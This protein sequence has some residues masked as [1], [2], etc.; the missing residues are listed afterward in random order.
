[1]ST[2]QDDYYINYLK[3]QTIKARWSSTVHVDSWKFFV[4]SSNPDGG[5]P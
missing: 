1:M 3:R 2:K 5:Q 4:Q